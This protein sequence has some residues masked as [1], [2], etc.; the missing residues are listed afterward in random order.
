VPP[1][2][3]I[4]TRRRR[5]G[6]A[7]ALVAIGCGALA[8]ASVH[9]KV[10]EVESRTGAPVEVVVA[11]EEIPPGTRLHRGRVRRVL[12]VRAVPARYAP[13]DG[14][15]APHEALGFEAAVPVPRGA[16]VTAAMLRDPRA[17]AAPSAP[18]RSGQ[19]LVEVAVTGGRE[20]AAGGVP[21]R[22]DVLVTT[23]GRTGGGRTFVA[24][25]DVEVVYA[26]PA[27]ASDGADADGT[28]P[29]TVA[30][31]RVDARAAVFLTAAQNFARELRLLTRPAGDRGRVGRAE[32]DDGGL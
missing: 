23:E 21:A 18:I 31:L 4:V 17:R 1:T 22:V 28:A 29:D 19:R 8:A 12:T 32:V 11:A 2:A 16:Y 25:E 30:T 27:R 10:E 13:R 26:R 15:G 24:L 14:L 20:L 3:S 7:L 5:R 6:V 9:D